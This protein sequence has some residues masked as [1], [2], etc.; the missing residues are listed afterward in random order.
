M[1][2]ELVAAD[3]KKIGII[4]IKKVGWLENFVR[5]YTPY[6]ESQKESRVTLNYPDGCKESFVFGSTDGDPV[7]CTQY[8]SRTLD[9]KKIAERISSHLTLE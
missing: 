1:E 4:N 6:V 3:G 5:F 9:A 8:F 7:M 2:A